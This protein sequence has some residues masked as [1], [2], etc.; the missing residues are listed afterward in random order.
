MLHCDDRRLVVAQKNHKFPQVH[1]LCIFCFVYLPL[2]TLASDWQTRN[3]SSLS[4][5]K[6]TT[7]TTPLDKHMQHKQVDDTST[8]TTTMSGNPQQAHA[9]IDN[10]ATVNTTK[11]CL[12]G[13]GNWGSAMATIIG[14]NCAR[15]PFCHTQVNMWVYEENVV[16]ADGTTDKLSN[17]INQRHENIKYL[18][19]I[20]VPDN[21]VAIPDLATACRDANLLVFVLPHQFLLP[22]LPILCQHVHPTNCRAIS[23]MKGLGK[24]F[25]S[26][27][28]V[29]AFVCVCLFCHA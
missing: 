10:V 20:P 19:G 1:F 15:L 23:L 11:V 7:T 26:V 28:F 27:L 18:P 3:P 13:S 21:V 6:A 14:P 24:T 8:S 12:I 22:L 9:I 2:L 29:Y 25:V 16:L 5:P 17:I 4:I